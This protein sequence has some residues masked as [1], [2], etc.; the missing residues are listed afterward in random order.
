MVDFQPLISFMEVP[1]P[2]FPLF[3]PLFWGKSNLQSHSFEQYI[4]A[5]KPNISNQ[6]DHVTFLFGSYYQFNYDVSF[7][8]IDKNTLFKCFNWKINEKFTYNLIYP[9]PY[10]WFNYSCIK[11]QESIKSFSENERIEVVQYSS[12]FMK[13]ELNKTLPKGWKIFYLLLLSFY[14]ISFYLL[15]IRWDHFFTASF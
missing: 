12:L 4:W 8:I 10:W 7:N 9:H 3:V 6:L 2:V 1:K 15:K 14:G 11:T 13:T 5:I